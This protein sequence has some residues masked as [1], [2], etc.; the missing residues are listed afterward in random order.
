[1]PLPRRRDTFGALI[2]FVM[3]LLSMQVFLMTVALDGLLTREPALAWASVAVSIVLFLGT[4]LF[5]GWLR[6]GR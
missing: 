6:G 3:I 1:M 4:L 2:V 5:H